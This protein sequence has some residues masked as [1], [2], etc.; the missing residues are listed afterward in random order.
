MPSPVRSV[1]LGRS[2]IFIGLV[3]AR[4]RSVSVYVHS[5]ACGA[6]ADSMTLGR[7]SGSKFILGRLF[8]L[9]SCLGVM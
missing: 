3:H 9:F 1:R 2:S 6:L 4:V 7:E 8:G 5:M